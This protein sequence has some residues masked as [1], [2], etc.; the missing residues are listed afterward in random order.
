[1]TQQ[2]FLSALFQRN[3]HGFTGYPSKTLA[4]EFTDRLFHFLFGA[5]KGKMRNLLDV[6]NAYANLQGHLQTLLQ[7]VIANT[8]TLQTAAEAFFE[9][10]PSIYEVLLEDANAILEFDPAAR[11]VEEVLIAYPGFFAT[12]V[13]R[14]AHA[15]WELDVPVLPRIL[16]EY[17][18]SNTGIDI[19]PGATIGKAFAIDHGTGIVIGE[20]T[21]I[22][23]HVK[24]YQGVTLGALNVAKSKGADTKRHP[25]IEDNVII[26]SGASILGGTTVVGHDSIIGGN[27][28]LTYS[29]PAAS[30]VY[31][32][33]EIRV[34]DNNPFP[35]PLNF[36]I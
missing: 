36:V 32:K 14:F 25:T 20:T 26:Y 4:A 16:T 34:K 5:T 33:S 30:V 31:H 10:I 29:V 21:V 24:I 19:H 17:A 15:L 11:S 1:M 28:F 27:V 35:E 22:G 23:D 6:E 13:Y 3:Q 18:H 12:A 2:Q 7:D 9:E 8:Q